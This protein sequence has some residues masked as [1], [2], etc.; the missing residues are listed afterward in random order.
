LYNIPRPTHSYFRAAILVSVVSSAGGLAA[1]TGAWAGSRAP[2][3]PPAGR[4]PAAIPLPATIPIF[5]LPDLM[6]FPGATVPLHIFEPRYRAMVAEAL[7]GNRIIGMVLLRPGYEPDY[8]RSPSIFPLGCAGIIEDVEALPNGEYNIL[9]RAIAKFR[10]TREETGKPYR[11]AY[12]TTIPEVLS[13]QDRTALSTQRQQLEMLLAGSA[14][15]LGLGRIPPGLSD[16]ALV[17][18]VAQHIDIDPLDRLKLLDQ[19]NPLARARALA[20]LL[21]KMLAAPR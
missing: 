8:E 17:D 16:E 14:G 3:S 19:A 9:L 2:Q 10:I 18:G 5:P 15:R 6:L 4:P 7:D 20:E 13:A 1:P 11:V 12:V 21:D